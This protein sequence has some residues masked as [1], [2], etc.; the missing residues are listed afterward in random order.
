MSWEDVPRDPSL[1]LLWRKF[2]WDRCAADADF[3]AYIREVCRRDFVFYV[4]TFVWIYNPWDFDNPCQ[5]FVFYDLP[6]YYPEDGPYQYGQLHVA[7]ELA[8]AVIEHYTIGVTKTRRTGMSWTCVALFDWLWRFHYDIALLVLS[9]VEAYVDDKGNLNAIM[10]K[11]D[12]IEERL[13]AFLATRGTKHSDT[14]GRK[15]LSIYNKRTRSKISGESTNDNAGRAGRAG[16]VLRDEEAHS[17]N[18]LLIDRA[19]DDNTQCQLRISTPNGI[20]NSHYRAQSSGAYRWVFLH[21][22]QMPDVSA[23]MY[24][25]SPKGEIEI[26]DTAWHEKNP[27]YEFVQ[28]PGGF[29]GLRS[30]WYD[31]ECRKRSPINIAQELDMDCLAAGS[32]FFEPELINTI[33]TEDVR[34]PVKVGKVADFVAIDGGIRDM[35]LAPMRIWFHTDR[36]GKPYQETTYVMGVDISTGT[37]ASDTAIT[38]IDAE[39]GEKVAEYVSN[40]ISPEEAAKLCVN[41]ANWFTTP[42]GY[43]FMIWDAGGPGLAFG[44]A[45]VE[46]HKYSNIYYHSE[47]AD[48]IAN[49]KTRPGFPWGPGAKRLLLNSYQQALK[50]KKFIQRSIEAAEQ[51]DCYVYTENS[52]EHSMARIKEDASGNKDNHGDI[53]IADALAWRAI[54][55]MPPPVPVP[56]EFPQD[57]SCPAYRMKLRKL[58]REKRKDDTKRWVA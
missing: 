58:E 53:I 57:M 10:P 17:D 4:H 43:C 35:S 29:K 31:A 7:Q 52:I 42:K 45:V 23:G 16:A 22:S 1:N 25:V 6:E 36:V 30:P 18:G 11:M 20:K 44:K 39:T 37:G 3:A 2:I 50:E 27:G 33:R 5:Q 26:L 32:P 51:A 54:E 47:D 34:R 40:L 55:K 49:K 14:H 48:K 56:F 38:V 21:W 15:N 8:K 13:P 19:L 24:R 28:K 9:R 41:L 12:Y 46:V